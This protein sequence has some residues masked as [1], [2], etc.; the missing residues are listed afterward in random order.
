MNA[1]GFTM[2]ELT[3]SL[4]ILT[5]S[6]L[7]LGYTTARL[8]RLAADAE[9]R[10]LALQVAEDRIARIQLHPL[11]QHLDSVFGESGTDLPFLPGH[12]R[13]TSLERVHLPG[14]R[15]GKPIDYTR[16]TV[17]VDGPGLSEPVSRTVSIGMS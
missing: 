6:V 11:Y 9:A 14:G 1:R 2:A 10:A 12:T 8:T 4:A 5:V 3:I 7:G 17:T 13:T 16:V 15:P